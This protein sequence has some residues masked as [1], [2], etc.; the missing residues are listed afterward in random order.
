MLISLSGAAGVGKT[1]LARQLL[2]LPH[3]RLLPNHTTRDPRSTD[4]PDEYIYVKDDEFDAGSTAGEYLWTV[5][6]HGNRYATSLRFVADAL[7]KGGATRWLMLLTPDRV[8]TLHDFLGTG[9]TTI[10]SFFVLA[11]S[12]NILRKRL[13]QRGEDESSVE[14]RISDCTD[15]NESARRRPDIFKLIEDNDD[16]D[17]K[18]RQILGHLDTFQ[19]TL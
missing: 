9:A 2:S 8:K 15:W 3:F 13:L 17:D 7:A 4:L 14:R 11:P 10:Q 12:E 1:S 5:S 6:I 16:L 19:L 18:Y